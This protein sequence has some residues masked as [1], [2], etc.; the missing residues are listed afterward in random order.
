MYYFVNQLK[1][2]TQSDSS[3]FDT[4]QALSKDMKL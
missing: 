1:Y 2:I 4:E 3:Q